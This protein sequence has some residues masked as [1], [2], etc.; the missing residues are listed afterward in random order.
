MFAQ[1]SGHI[2]DSS[3]LCIMTDYIH[4]HGV[5]V[6]YC[7]HNIHSTVTAGQYV[8]IIIMLFVYHYRLYATRP[9]LGQ[10]SPSK[11]YYEYIT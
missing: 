8:W 4:N 6:L 3:L 9:A 10:Y 7:I 1:V 5:C 2:Y 11:N